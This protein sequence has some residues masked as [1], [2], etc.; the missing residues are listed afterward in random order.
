MAIGL[1]GLQGDGFSLPKGTLHIAP[2]H[3]GNPLETALLS[4][5]T[6]LLHVQGQSL[7]NNFNFYDLPMK[8]QKL[9]WIVYHTEENIHDQY[10]LNLKNKIIEIY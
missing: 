5:M 7:G 2:T 9:N 4:I 8:A 10:Y 3:E 1:P 6:K